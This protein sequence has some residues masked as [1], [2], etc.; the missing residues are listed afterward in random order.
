MILQNNKGS[1]IA[2]V[3]YGVVLMLLL[4]FTAINTLNAKIIENAYNSLRDSVLAA[5]SGSVIHLLTDSS[6]S[7]QAQNTVITDK[8][9]D[10]YLQLALG[11]I[12]N[13]T[14]NNSST[15]VQ[16]A[17]INNF[18]KLDHKK[19]VNST[20]A[21]LDDAVVRNKKN[22]S[23][24][25]IGINNTEKFKI[26]MFFIEPMYSESDYEKYFNIIMYTN[27]DCD[28]DGNLTGNGRVDLAGADISGSSMKDVYN[29]IQSRI[30]GLVNDHTIFNED[31]NTFTTFSINLN[32]SGGS[33]DNLVRRMETVPYYLIVVKDFALP[34]LFNGVETNSNESIFKSAFTSLSGDGKLKTPMCALNSGKTERKLKEE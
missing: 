20:M 5:S 28:E 3:I 8:S 13:R 31:E 25:K 24:D 9:Y 23:G 22:S 29:N 16:G 19:V 26:L 1:G 32:P 2:V 7:T 10:V 33:L 21:L 12:I 11:Y 15:S 27:G 4:I 6:G 34:T 30:N 17:E 14:D 18:I